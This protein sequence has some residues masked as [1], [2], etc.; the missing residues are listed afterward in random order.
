MAS[1]D[2]VAGV[3]DDIDDVS[4]DVKD[5]DDGGNQPI[6]VHATAKGDVSV[7]KFSPKISMLRNRRQE[8]DICVWF[9]YDTRCR[10]HTL[11]Q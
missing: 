5:A 3:V 8:Q 4:D 6:E 2:C 11:E 10:L 1:H 9:Q 7:T